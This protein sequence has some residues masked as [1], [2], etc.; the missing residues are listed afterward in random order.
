[1]ALRRGGRSTGQ[2]IVQNRLA[3]MAER[4][5][6]QDEPAAYRQLLALPGRCA[7]HQGVSQI[8]RLPRRKSARTPAKITLTDLGVRNALFSGAP[9]LWESDPQHVGP[10]IETL[11][12]SV[13]RGPGIQVHF[14]RD[15]ENPRNRNST[16]IE[17]DFVPEDPRR[18][19]DSDR[20][21]ISPSTARQ[22]LS[23]VT[24]IYGPL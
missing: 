14:F 3:E 16:I 7:A 2:E 24:G 5:R 20:N 9:S 6:N 22:G 17:V 8:S 13:I 15:H 1:M 19:G 10:L 11:A 23:R 12:Q 18:R 21:K 4:L